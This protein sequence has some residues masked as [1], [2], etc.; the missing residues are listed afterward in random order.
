[1]EERG[2]KGKDKG[3]LDFLEIG[4]R[5]YPKNGEQER[6]CSK[7]NGKAQIQQEDEKAHIHDCLSLLWQ[8]YLPA[9]QPRHKA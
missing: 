5:V 9:G 2:S 1:M 3:T 4:E 6:F 8:G 7:H